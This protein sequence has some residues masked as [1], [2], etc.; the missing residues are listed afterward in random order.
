ML[1][2]VVAVVGAAEGGSLTS[3][4]SRPDGA[5]RGPYTACRRLRGGEG[6]GDEG[7]VCGLR[8]PAIAAEVS[9]QVDE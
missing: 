6:G 9:G 5:R 2:P 4:C 7:T 1:M 3:L 8:C